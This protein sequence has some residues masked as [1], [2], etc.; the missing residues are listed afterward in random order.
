MFGYASFLIDKLIMHEVLNFA[1]VHIARRF[2]VV[3][4]DFVGV[5][6]L[7]DLV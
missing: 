1:L 2:M 4:D 6:V 3:S 7:L 5:N